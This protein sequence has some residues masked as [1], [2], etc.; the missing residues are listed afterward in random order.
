M[1]H[2][3]EPEGVYKME[4]LRL[5]NT[6]TTIY[7][8]LVDF[9]GTDFEATPVTFAT[10]DTKVSKDGAALGNT[11]SN[12]VHVGGG[13]YKLAL[14]AGEVNA[15]HIAIVIIDQTATK[16]WEDQAILIDCSGVLWDEPLT[17]S[18]HNDPTSSGR[19]LRTIQEYEGYQDGSVWIDTENGTAGTVSN[20][21]G[22]VINPVLTLADA[23][24][25]ATNLK[26]NSFRIVTGSTI[27]LASDTLGKI[28]KG[29][30][31]T[32]ALGGQNVGGSH[33]EGAGV[34]GIGTGDEAHYHKCT[35]NTVTLSNS[36]IT[37]CAI[38]A[39]ITMSAIGDYFLVDCHS[40][41]AGSA[42]PT[43]DVGVAVANTNLNIRNYSG[44]V[45]I[46]NLGQLGTDKISMEGNGQI[47]LNA[48]CVGG[49]VDI[50]GNIE[51]TDNG[52]G[53]TI[54]DAVRYDS[55]T[56]VDLIMDEPIDAPN[57]NVA[58][59]LAK[60]VRDG[61][62]F[63]GYEGGFI[64]IDTVDGVAGSESFVNGITENPVKSI[65]DANILSAALGIKS[66]KI[67]SGSSIA[68]A[69]AQEKQIFSGEDWDL[70]LGGQ[71]I[72][73]T[74]I[75]GA[76]ISGIGTAASHPHFTHCDM[77][78]A[79]L[80]P[81]D[82]FD[83]S[84]SGDMIFTAGSYFIHNCYSGVA[85]TGTPSIDVGAAVGDTNVN[86]RQYS[87]GMEFKN[88]GATGT[89]KVSFE[90]NG[91]C[92]LNA[93]CV[94]GDISIRGN[95]ELTDNS[96]TTTISDDSRY[97]YTKLMNDTIDELNA[98]PSGAAGVGPMIKFIYTYL[99]NKKSVTT[100]SEILYKDDGTTELGT[101]AITGDETIRTKDEIS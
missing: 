53:I 26:L 6:A 16:L 40:A 95:I 55:D 46:E 5:K 31:W 45:E 29:D 47:I 79:T 56:L 11:G 27:T 84:F 42:T 71:S 51:L 91:Q 96:V 54:F 2:I 57:H 20:E 94:G 41:I 43:I 58:K 15:D 39:T 98:I 7:F 81:F 90:G 86:L 88:L 37:D 65:A 32:L 19:R 30:R 85:G 23:L 36:H 38:A 21:S 34:S 87:G 62:E 28:F 64:Y 22:T 60:F 89:D 17:G 83:C 35:I 74:A 67:I 25:I 66:F 59:S 50:R 101:S 52:S 78:G 69:A 82:S 3:G 68:F 73:G 61:V 33:F 63:Q 92:I 100:G 18:T 44:G 1:A 12:P 72:T 99:R 48:N 13:M 4:L 75:H 93:N 24:T 70:A 49:E 76:A 8:P 77:N 14:T 97:S 10:G 80:D 9:G